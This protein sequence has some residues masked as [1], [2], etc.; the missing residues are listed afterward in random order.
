MNVEINKMSVYAYMLCDFNFD[1]LDYVMWTHLISK[2]SNLV[3]ILK[4]LL[5]DFEKCDFYSQA[6]ITKSSHKYVV[7]ESKSLD[8]LHFDI[9]ELDETLTRNEK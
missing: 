9:C 8:L 3:L 4:L 7:R 2:L 6:K 5:N 1:M